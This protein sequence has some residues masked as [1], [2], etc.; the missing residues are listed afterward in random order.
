M[1]CKNPL[2]E[3]SSVDQHS[4]SVFSLYHTHSR[5]SALVSKSAF[6]VH[7]ASTASTVSATIRSRS[8]FSGKLCNYPM[9]I[10]S[11]FSHFCIIF[12]VTKPLARPAP[13]R[14][15]TSC[16]AEGAHRAPNVKGPLRTCP[17]QIPPADPPA[18]VLRTTAVLHDQTPH[19]SPHNK[20]YKWTPNGPPSSRPY[21]ICKKTRTIM[22]DLQGDTK[23]I[24]LLEEKKLAQAYFLLF[25]PLHSCLALLFS[26]LFSTDPKLTKRESINES[27]KLPSSPSTTPQTIK[28]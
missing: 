7:P 18:V 16:S 17:Q 9:A 23:T 14:N 28:L 19:S 12:C 21:Q 4:K 24:R 15:P 13:D 27:L 1:S 2:P 26:P 25:L 8:F 10:F 22:Q 5:L 3:T 20:S 11:T 6:N